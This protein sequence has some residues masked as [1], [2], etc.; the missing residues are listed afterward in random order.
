MVNQGTDTPV[1]CQEMAAFNKWEVFASPD[2][3]CLFFCPER[4][5]DGGFTRRCVRVYLLPN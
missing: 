5:A 3:S 2:L 1:L 4:R